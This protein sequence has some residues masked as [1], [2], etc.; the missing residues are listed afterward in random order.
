M[1]SKMSS[2]RSVLIR[3]CMSNIQKEVSQLEHWLMNLPDD[4]P[5]QPSHQTTSD[6]VP[7]FDVAKLYSV[8]DK[9]SEQ[10]SN[11]QYTLSNIIDRLDTIENG[12][13]R[14][15]KIHIEEDGKSSNP[16]LDNHCEPLCN[17]IIEGDKTMAYENEYPSLHAPVNNLYENEYPS[18]RIPV[19]DL[20]VSD[21]SDVSSVKTPSIVPDVPEDKSVVPDINSVIDDDNTDR[22][23]FEPVHISVHTQ[24]E[25]NIIEEVKK[26]EV[27]IEKDEE[28]EIVEVK[29]KEEKKIIVIDEVNEEEVVEVEEEEEEVVEE[30]EEEVVEEEEEEEEEEGLELEEI[31]YKGIKYYKDAENFIYTISEDEQPSENPVGYWKEKTN[32]IAFYKTK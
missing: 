11:Q 23:A 16:W 18:L 10:I 31:E 20:Y 29:V 17:E 22:V 3:T 7:G 12:Y 13:T 19:N 28:V 14:E 5:S 27:V 2:I 4:F 8:V 25:S 1:S 30:E 9:L 6:D 21:N 24:V 26:K 32:S 15:R